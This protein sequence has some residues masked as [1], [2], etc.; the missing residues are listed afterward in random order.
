MHIEDQVFP[1]RCGHLAGKSVVNV[2]EMQERLRVAAEAIR[3]HKLDMLLCARTDAAATEGVDG[4]VDRSLAYLECGANM[5]FPE[6]LRTREEFAEVARRLSGKTYLLANMTE[7]GVSPWLSR[8]ELGAM[9]Y[10]VALYPVST[11]RVAAKATETL[12]TQVAADARVDLAA[13]QSRQDLYQLLKY[14][15]DHDWKS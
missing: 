11:L 14:S 8:D 1:K 5:I 6:G 13:M 4:V 9:G 3:D 7:F 2:D 12:L 10:H 15:P